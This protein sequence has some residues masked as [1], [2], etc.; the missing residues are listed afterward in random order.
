M[1]VNPPLLW[2]EV[3][4]KHFKIKKQEI[5]EQ[6]KEWNTLDASLKQTKLS[7]MTEFSKL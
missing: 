7:L 4:E 1:L 2:K 5:L 3:I 6:A